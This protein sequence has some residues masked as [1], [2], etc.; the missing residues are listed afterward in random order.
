MGS[1]GL[2]AVSVPCAAEEQMAQGEMLAKR[3][4]SSNTMQSRHSA[5]CS[6]EE[7]EGLGRCLDLFLQKKLEKGEI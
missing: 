2:A 1:D 3:A 5:S 4:E 7:S 6:E